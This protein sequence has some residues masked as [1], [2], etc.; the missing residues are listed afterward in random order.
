M[1]K[2]MWLEYFL[3]ISRNFQLLAYSLPSSLK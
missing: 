2:A 3:T 1:G